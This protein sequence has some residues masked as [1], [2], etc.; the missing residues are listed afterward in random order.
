MDKSLSL[1]IELPCSKATT[2][3]EEAVI[4]DVFRIHSESRGRRGR[5]ALT[6]H[7]ERLN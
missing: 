1:V 6:C 7:D 4:M 3:S 5:D 2:N